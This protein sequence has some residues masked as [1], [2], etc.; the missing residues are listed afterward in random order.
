MRTQ[1]LNE[2]EALSDP[3]LMWACWLL[4]FLLGDARAL[5]PAADVRSRAVF[6]ALLRYATTAGAPFK[7]AVVSLL[8]QA[9][10]RT[11]VVCVDYTLVF[12]S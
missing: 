5:V 12:I 3:S 7:H 10:A 1:W 6:D 8:T 11:H 4:R 2:R 9:R